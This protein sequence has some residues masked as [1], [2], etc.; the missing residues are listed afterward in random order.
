V[1]V[2]GTTVDIHRGCEE[3]LAADAPGSLFDE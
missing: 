3:Q 1:Y 2:A